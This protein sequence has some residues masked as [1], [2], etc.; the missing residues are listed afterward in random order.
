MWAMLR[1]HPDVYMPSTKE[2]SFFVPEIRRHPD[3]L[4]TYLSLFAPAL[5]HQRTGEASPSY[6]WS[7]TAAERIAEARPDARIIAIL[8]EPASFLRSLHLELLRIQAETEKS[9]RKAIALEDRRAEGKSIPRN[10]TRPMFLAY[11]EHVR[12]VEQ[13]QRFHAVFPREQILVLI[14]EEYRADNAGTVEQVLRFLGVE[15]ALEVASVQANPTPEIR[16]PNVD[17]LVRS[18]YLGRGPLSRLGKKAVK[19]ITTNSL[20]RQALAVQR[21]AQLGR[22][23]SVDEALMLDLRRRFKGEVIRLSDYLEHDLVKLWG[24]DQL[25]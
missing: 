18:L 14:Y 24:Y 17:A 2:P 21:S 25:D 20:R 5:P 19:A 16:A 23:S 15:D 12:Y 22:P 13:L 7:R 11:S 3:T 4:E 8:R 9:F 6:L 1:T 10:S